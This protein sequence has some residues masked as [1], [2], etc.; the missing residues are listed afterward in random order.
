MK[1]YCLAP[2]TLYLMLT[3][4][5]T[6]HDGHIGALFGSWALTDV[7]RDGDS[8]EL[9][10]ETVF[11]FQNEIVRIVGYVDQPYYA[12]TRY[13]NFTHEGDALIL[14]FASE[15]TPTNGRGY[16]APE[17]L[18]FPKDENILHFDVKH[19]NGSVLELTLVNEGMTTCYSF[20]KTW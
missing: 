20:R 18:Y 7:T 3:C 14:K 15:P 2:L 5:C 6:Q 11:S 4:G 16:M 12:M 1:T 8:A 17:W 19:L 13:G 10:Y 9:E